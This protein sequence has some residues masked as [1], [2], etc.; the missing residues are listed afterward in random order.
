MCT[1]VT[2]GHLMTTLRQ[3]AALVHNHQWLDS[4]MVFSHWLTWL[5]RSIYRLELESNQNRKFEV[6]WDLNLKSNYVRLGLNSNKTIRVRLKLK[7]ILN[8]N[9]TWLWHFWPLA[10]WSFL[11]IY[12][13]FRSFLYFWLILAL[14]DFARCSEVQPDHT[15]TPKKEWKQRPSLCLYRKCV[16]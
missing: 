7:S 5:R 6:D 3:I 11:A 13:P 12:G 8:P 15:Q 2:N 4:G 1:L 9:Y 10:L 14:F 16:S